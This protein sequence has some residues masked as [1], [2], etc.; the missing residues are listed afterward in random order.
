MPKKNL[1]NENHD[2]QMFNFDVELYVQDDDETHHSSG[3]YSILKDKWL[4]IP[5]RKEVVIDYDDIKSKSQGYMDVLPYLNT[6]LHREN[7][8]NVI[9]LIDKIKGRL[10]RM[11]QSGLEKN[12]EYSVENL[13]FKILRRTNFIKRLNDIKTMAYDTQMSINNK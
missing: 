9:E 11:R 10:K 3:L 8:T 5:N 1:W 7:Y 12:G 13:S 6:Q 2:I 4:V